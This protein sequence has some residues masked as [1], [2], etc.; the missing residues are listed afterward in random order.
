MCFAH[1]DLKMHFVPQRR[2]IFE[3]RNFQKWSKHGVF[4]AFSLE[5]VLRTT[6]ACKCSFLISPGGSTPAALASLL[7]DAPDPQTIGKTQCFATFVTF[8][9]PVSS[10]FWLFLFLSS[11]LLFCA[12]HLSILSE[13]WLLNFL[14]LYCCTTNNC[15]QH[16]SLHTNNDC[17]LD[18]R[19][20]FKNL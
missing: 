12:F 19:N 9:A 14:W 20:R 2:T 5:N 1:V 18:K 11:T 15:S 7:F 8:R 13:V 4:C 10:V 6:T 17:W 16:V 3:H